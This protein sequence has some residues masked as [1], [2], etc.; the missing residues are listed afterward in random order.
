MI[1]DVHPVRIP[2]PDR[3]FFTH[4]G[5]RVKGQKGTGSRIWIRNTSEKCMCRIFLN[6]FF[7]GLVAHCHSFS[8]FII[9]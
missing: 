6:F 7:K 8:L 5:S 4:R 3:D 1:R 9:I 2:D